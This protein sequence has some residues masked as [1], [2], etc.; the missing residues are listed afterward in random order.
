MKRSLSILLA[1]LLCIGMLPMQVQAAGLPFTDV[2]TGAWYYEDVKNA[3]ESGLING[4]KPTVFAPEDNMVYAEA[5]KLAACMHQ[6]YTTGSVT[7]QNGSPWYQTYVDYALQNKIITKEYDPAIDALLAK[8][9]SDAI[10]VRL[11]AG[12]FV[13]LLPQDAHAP[14]CYDAA[15]QTVKKIIGKVKL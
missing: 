7:L 2:P 11:T 3:Y 1:M 6:K 10:P 5:I 15:P 9:D 13:V 8:L 4:K 14:A 12:T